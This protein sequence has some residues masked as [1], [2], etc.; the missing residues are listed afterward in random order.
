LGDIHKH[1]GPA[2]LVYV[3]FI[4]CDGIVG[5]V[6]DRINRGEGAALLRCLPGYFDISCIRLEI[7]NLYAKYDFAARDLG[8]VDPWMRKRRSRNR[9]SHEKNPFRRV[10]IG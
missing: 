1:E 6:F 10:R 8:A 2:C 3:V 7:G 9:R 4:A 5:N